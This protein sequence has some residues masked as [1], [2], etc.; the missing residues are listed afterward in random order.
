L[1]RLA[2]VLLGLIFAL[3]IVE[4]SLHLFPGLLPLAVRQAVAIYNDSSNTQDTYKPFVAD[5]ELIFVPQPDLDLTIHSG[6]ELQY[7]VQ[8]RRLDDTA[9]GFRDIGSI[10][11]TYAVAVGDSFTWGTYVTAPETWSE[12][13]QAHIHAPVLNLGV[14]GY[15]PSQYQIMTKEHGLIHQPKVVIWGFFA[16]NDMVNSA[17]YADWVAGGKQ[18][19]NYIGRVSVTPDFLSRYVRLYEL[20]KLL[21]GSGLYQQ[22]S[23]TLTTSMAAGYDWTFYPRDLQTLADGD[24]PQ[25]AKGWVLT[26]EAILETVTAVHAANAELVILIIPA[27]E[28][29]YW[30]LIAPNLD[31]PQDF[32]L[33][34][35]IRTLVNFCQQESLHCLDLTPTFIEQANAGAEL[36][37]RQDAHWSPTGHQLAATLLANY[38]EEQGLQP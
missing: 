1:A 17:D 25:V 7:S 27:K 14:R 34:E 19:P 16:G 36:Y 21:L 11:P 28:L 10:D 24:L 12:Q 5:D 23:S 3:L 32:D 33:A 22:R 18:S 8:T 35:P 29:V 9:V 38:L 4:I 13:L 26:Q 20:S 6:L 37:F 15:G 31:N 30:P 2:L